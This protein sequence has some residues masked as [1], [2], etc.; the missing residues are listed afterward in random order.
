MADMGLFIGWGQPVRGREAKSL[1]V[2]NE[3]MQFW[4]RLQEQGRI[5]SYE[6]GLLAP[7]G[8][9]LGGFA[10][11]RGSREQ[12][13]A[14]EADEEFQRMLTRADLIVEQLGVVRVAMAEAMGQQ[15]ALFRGAIDELT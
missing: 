9:D 2:F 13:D 14:V 6:V 3:S 12:F 1:D 10:L 4:Q 7:H 5:D 11:M 8:G 15:L